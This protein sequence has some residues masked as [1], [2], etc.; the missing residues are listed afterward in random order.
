M[1]PRDKILALKVIRESAIKPSLLC[2]KKE[3]LL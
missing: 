2:S 3:L 1:V